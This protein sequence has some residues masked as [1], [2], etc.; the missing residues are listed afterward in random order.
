MYPYVT[1]MLVVCYS[2]V[3]V[4]SVCYSYVTRMY[5][6]GVL[7]MID[8]DCDNIVMGRDFNF[9][10]KSEFDKQGG[11][12]NTSHPKALAEIRNVQINL[13]L[14][15]IWRDENPLTTRYTRRRRNPDISCR[16]DFFL[17]SRGVYGKVTNSDILPGY[18]TDHST[19]TLSLGVTENPRGPGLWKLNTSF[20]TDIEYINRIKMVI[21]Q[22]WEDYKNDNNVDDALLWEIFNFNFL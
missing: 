3:S 20:L 12:V 4:C 14:G 1:R 2:Y 7:V 19:I 21:S 13:D 22:T 15:D 11:R 6:C 17:I 8:F 5:S 16:L 9:I 10:L 18:K